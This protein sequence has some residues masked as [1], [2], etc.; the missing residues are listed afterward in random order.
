MQ[1]CCFL[2]QI[3]R[4]ASEFIAAELIWHTAIHLCYYYYY[5]TR[6]IN[7]LAINFVP[8]WPSS[9]S[10]WSPP[11]HRPNGMWKQQI[12]ISLEFVGCRCTNGQQRWRWRIVYFIFASASKPTLSTLRVRVQCSLSAGRTCEQINRNCFMAIMTHSFG[13]LTVRRCSAR[14]RFQPMAHLNA[15]SFDSLPVLSAIRS[16]ALFAR[17]CI[18]HKV[19]SN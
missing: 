15:I 5:S 7:L 11:S 18:A 6:R 8:K 19:S 1:C 3:S 14:N 16:T 2:W 10:P 9:Q 13:P 17:V 4:H 12:M